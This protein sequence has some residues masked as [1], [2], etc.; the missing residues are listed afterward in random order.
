MCITEINEILGPKR[1]LKSLK[2]NE[3][4]EISV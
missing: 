3:F 1:L 4:H 2:F